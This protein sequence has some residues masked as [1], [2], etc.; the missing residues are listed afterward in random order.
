[1]IKKKV[2]LLLSV[3]LVAPFLN[4]SVNAQG[5][6]GVEDIVGSTNFIVSPSV[7]RPNQEVRVI[8]EGS[9]IDLNNALLTW[10]VNGQV[11][12]SGRG[13]KSISFVS[14]E[15][16]S[17]SLV[18]LVI[19]SEGKT[20][21][22]SVVVTPGSV[23]ILWQGNSYTPPFYK[24]R[25]LWSTRGEIIFTA[26]PNVIGSNG[27]KLDPRQLTYKWVRNGTAEGSLSGYGRNSYR[28]SESG[29][30]FGQVIRVDVYDGEKLVGRSSINL[31]PSFPKNLIY[32]NNPLLGYLFQNEISNNFI[33]KNEEV[34]F[35]AFPYFFSATSKDDPL[36]S[37]RW[38][39]NDTSNIQIGNQV[40]FR[41]PE[42]SKGKS[43]IV[44][45]TKHLERISQSASK[46]FLVQFG[47]EKNF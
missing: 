4:I 35:G 2:F 24:G 21:N 1:M 11:I 14:G 32:E 13:E 18:R 27:S 5:A 43:L 36:I 10:S 15:I 9:G 45:T 41:A 25:S 40:T 30:S 8:V 17:N 7:P 31:R 29:L 39:I 12:K 38:K 28:F 23:D 34:T 26:I 3:F 20:Y 47:D 16:G 42:N 33:L 6:V 19:V 46:D 44:L 37:Y 22:K